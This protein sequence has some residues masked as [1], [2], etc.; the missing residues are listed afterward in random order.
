MTFSE[1]QVTKNQDGTY[2]IQEV[3]IFEL[4]EHKKFNYDQNWIQQALQN[5]A[6]LKKN[7]FLPRLIIG[8]T[9]EGQEKPAVGFLDNLKLKGKEVMADIVNILPEVFEQIKKR[10][11]PGR[12][13][14][15]NPSKNKFTA[16]AL[17]GGTEPHFQF[18]PMT[19]KYQA[20]AG[21]EWIEFHENENTGV[22]IELLNFFKS[23]F[24]NQEGNKKMAEIDV[25]A[26][27]DQIK[28]DLQKDFEAQFQ[29]QYNAKFKEEFGTTPEQFRE[30]LANDRKEILKKRVEMFGE[31][32]KKKYNL[33][34]ALVDEYLVPMVNV[35]ETN[36]K[37]K[38]ADKE[39]DAFQAVEA[40]AEKLNAMAK[41]NQIVVNFDE[42]VQGGSKDGN[43]NLKNNSSVIDFRFMDK[44]DADE[45]HKKVLKCQAEK[46]LKT[47]EEALQLVLADK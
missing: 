20:E 47:Y 5:F 24:T 36:Q 26:I 10:M 37:I 28:S 29:V 11:W 41:V 2:N 46:G 23:H 44:T 31:N 6:G 15:V 16:L 1:H 22:L 17:L 13:V 14:E 27:T 19:V 12:S 7:D 43:P 18:S 21:G 25:K 30:K 34:P 9:I 40:F 33:A 42:T 45:L 3:P 32:L 4:G 35:L 8:H 38:F 39:G